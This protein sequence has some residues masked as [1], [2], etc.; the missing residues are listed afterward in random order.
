MSLWYGGGCCLTWARWASTLKEGTHENQ[1]LLSG[2]LTVSLAL[3]SLP[4]PSHSLKPF[5]KANEA[6]PNIPG[7]YPNSPLEM[8]LKSG[9]PH[10]E[11]PLWAG[12]M[13]QPAHLH[14]SSWPLGNDTQHL[15][16]S[17]RATGEASVVA[18][19]FLL[20]TV[21]HSLLPTQP[22]DR[23]GTLAVTHTSLFLPRNLCCL[24]A[25]HLLW[26]SVGAPLQHTQEQH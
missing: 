9:L 25:T 19:Q 17:P 21:T 14:S 6:T 22:R 8:P 10:P 24:L 3:S 5:L 1:N 26:T 15:T 7:D 4:T 16:C 11:N 18:L 12:G 20:C 2:D 23:A 13:S